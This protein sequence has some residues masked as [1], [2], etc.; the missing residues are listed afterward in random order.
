MPQD[1]ILAM[2]GITKIFPGVKAL[3]NVNFYVKRGE[4]HCLI[5][6]NGAGKSTLMKLLAGV[7]PLDGGTIEFNGEKLIATN[8]IHSRKAGIAVIY[9]ELSLVGAL[10][11]AENILLNNY[12]SKVVSWRK[13][14]KAAQKYCER[15]KV[16]I[17]VTAIVNTLSIGQRQLVEIMK[18]LAT[19]AKLIVMDEP[20]ATLSN[21][22]F[23]ILLSIINDLK[24]QGITII[25]ISHRLEE[26]FQVG[27]QIT[28]LRDGCNVA[29]MSTEDIDVDRLVELM[30]GYRLDK[31]T[32]GHTSS[33][34]STEKVLQLEN[35][36]TH[37]V[38]NINIDLHRGEIVGLY[39][40][41][42][43]G[44]TEVL[45]SI[46]GV[47]KLKEGSLKLFGK[48]YTP[49]SPIDAVNHGIGLVPENRKTQGLVLTLPVWENVVLVSLPRFIKNGILSY[50][51][52]FSEVDDYVKKIRIK[53]PSVKTIMNNLSGGNQQKVI[54]AKWLLKDCELLLVDEPTQGIDVGA[55]EEIY[56]LL[57]STADNGKSIIVASSELDEL[58]IMCDRIIVMYEGEIIKTFV[59]AN[60]EEDEILQAAIAGRI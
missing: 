40:L 37:R 5:G 47:D 39:G 36:T 57:R 34:E 8:T 46:Y 14:N 27:D 51:R 60:A 21:E 33:I 59:T 49:H 4:V 32:I 24:Q 15:L 22:E 23:N 55:K 16:N 28:I 31:K 26:L 25:Y 41:I 58:R 11:V 2:E 18:A 42:G 3:D 12:N 10:T 9:Q 7:Y 6:A 52:M 50:R 29:T 44:R 56:K 30:I 48:T 45:R 17:D 43:S 53:T 20:S 19:G 35:V 13:M 38:R 1:N 54:L